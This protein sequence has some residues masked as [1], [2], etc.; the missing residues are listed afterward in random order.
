MGALTPSFLFD[1]ESNLRVISVNEYARMLKSLW[2]QRVTKTLTS[3]GKKDVIGW[4]L[5]T[6]T[7]EAQGKGGNVRFSDMHMIEQ[8]IEN[9]DA[10]RGL[11]I[12][13]QQFEDADGNGVAIGQKWVQNISA[14]SAYWPQKLIANLIKAGSS[15]LGY[16][17]K[18]L[19]SSS[20]TIGSAATN[21][22]PYNPNQPSL[23]GF[24]NWFTGA[25]SG[26]KGYPGAC[27]IDVTDAA[28]VDIARNNLNKVI[29][30]I[31]GS[32]LMPNGKDPRFLKATCLIHPPALTG[33]VQ[34]ITKAK[35]IGQAAGSSGGGSG[36][37]EA[38]VRN[39]GFGE[40]IEAP[41]LSAANGGSDTTYYVACEEIAAGDQLGALVYQVREPFAIQFYS[42][43]GSADGLDAVLYRAQELEWLTHGRNAGA[44]GHP[45]MIFRVDAT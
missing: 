20:E 19:F 36:D 21:A 22:H 23:G 37:I 28:T 43:S 40:P 29:A 2:Y 39:Y 31:A 7:I 42:G 17:G 30:Y 9:L 8:T 10:G 13:K 3:K 6:A 5:D 11:K 34:Q 25:A 4:L 16:D 38:M 18:N 14:Q 24:A 15:T 45:Y 41:E 1:F 12:R 44:P 32:I 27:P 33:R 35:F 26:T